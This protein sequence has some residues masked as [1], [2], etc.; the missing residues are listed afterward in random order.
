MD[1]VSWCYWAS[2]GERPRCG[3]RN[4]IHTYIL[5]S[6]PGI[7]NKRCGLESVPNIPLGG[8]SITIRERLPC[9]CVQ[10]LLSPSIAAD[11]RVVCAL[12]TTDKISPSSFDSVTRIGRVESFGSEAARAIERPSQHVPE[13]R[14]RFELAEISLY[15]ELS[16]YLSARDQ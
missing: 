10:T 3:D 8:A 7:S 16:R 9:A 2:G 4:T 1:F 6:V 13:L 14:L 15:S 12:F 11:A 5:G